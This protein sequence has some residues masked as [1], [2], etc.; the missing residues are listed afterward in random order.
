MALMPPIRQAF[1]LE[2]MSN[3]AGGYI[4]NQQLRD[5][6]RRLLSDG[7]DPVLAKIIY[8]LSVELADR[9]DLENP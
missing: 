1:I 3:M 8:D 9:F 5:Q 4:A 7:A 2:T 6:A